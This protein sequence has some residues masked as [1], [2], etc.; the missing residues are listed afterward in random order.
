MSPSFAFSLFFHN[1]SFGIDLTHHPKGILRIADSG[2][3]RLF[4]QLDLNRSLSFSHF[5]SH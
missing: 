1:R 4:F 2:L 5:I 3:G